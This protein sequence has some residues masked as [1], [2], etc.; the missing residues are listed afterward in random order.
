MNP[1]LFKWDTLRVVSPYDFRFAR[2]IAGFLCEIKLVAGGTVHVWRSS[3]GSK[4]FCHGLT[5]GGKNAPGGHVSPFTGIDVETILATDY[6]TVDEQ[7]ALPSDIVVWRGLMPDSTPHSAILTDVPLATRG[8]YL[9]YA[10]R[11]QTKNGMRPESN[12]TLELLIKRYGESYTVYR[13][14]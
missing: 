12:I 1:S 11:L 5:L 2:P 8:R 14:K 6:N 4:Y 7:F 3:D 9:N 13:L 10:T